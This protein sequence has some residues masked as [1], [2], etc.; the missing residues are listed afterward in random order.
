VT[1]NGTQADFRQKL[2]NQISQLIS[3]SQRPPCGLIKDVYLIDKF[4]AAAT[5][6]L[7]IWVVP[8]PPGPSMGDNADTAP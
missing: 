4:V 7:G 1:R 6:R 5:N 8:A 2:A 3:V